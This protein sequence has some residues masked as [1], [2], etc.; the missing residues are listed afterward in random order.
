MNH[1]YDTIFGWSSK[2]DQGA[3]LE[4]LLPLVKHNG[5]LRIAEIGVYQGKCT[6][7]WNVMLM[8]ENIDYEYHAIDHFKGSDEHEKNVDYYS[9][10]KHNLTPILDKINLIKNE[11]TVQVREYGNFY[12]D[13]VYIDASHDYY[14]VKRDL[15]VWYPKVKRHGIICGDDY[16]AGWDG[17]IRA[18]NDKFPKG[19]NIVGKQQWWYHKGE[20]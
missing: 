8:N 18:V 7:M 4:T 2:E 14:S 5:K 9:L 1:F 11:S 10:A 19:V 12:F 13:I 17:V 6:A 3:L 16:I 20:I 15:D